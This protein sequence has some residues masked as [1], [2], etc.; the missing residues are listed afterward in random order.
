[1]HKKKIYIVIGARP[2]FVKLAP[3]LDKMKEYPELLPV[4]IHT[5]QH[6]DFRMSESFFQDLNL[7]VPDFNLGVGSK[8]HGKQTA[9]IMEK[10][11]DICID[12]KPLAVV[13]IGDVNSTL[14]CALVAA[15]LQ[16][17]VIH[18]EA[19]CRNFDMT[20]PEEINRKLTD[21]ISNY[22]FCATEKSVEYLKNE[23][24]NQ[25]VFLPET[26]NTMP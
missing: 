11:E 24:I 3:L 9:E 25:N 13:V 20:M 26:Y 18:I 17:C 16:I 22:L 6:Y 14:A 23:G 8:T 19:G 5:G 10:F 1:M 4:V 7:P 15:K 12:S 2:N 21:H